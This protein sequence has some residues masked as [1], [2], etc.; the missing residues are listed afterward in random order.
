LR[1]IDNVA[2]P[3]LISASV[4][5]G[6]AYARA[7]YLLGRVGL[8]EQITAYPGELSGG[9]Q[10]RVSIARTLINSPSLVLADEPTGDL[11]EDTE[12]E[13]LELLLDLQSGENITLIIV[14]H[15][16]A[17]AQRAERIVQVRQGRIV[18]ETTAEMSPNRVRFAQFPHRSGNEE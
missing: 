3:A 18:G 6:V 17:I 16:L 4:D 12:A 9:E 8:R 11:D 15:N 10:R 2:L 5:A 13:I 1:A 7:E 14:T